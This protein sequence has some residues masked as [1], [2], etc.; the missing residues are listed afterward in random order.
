[1]GVGLVHK[2]KIKTATQLERHIKGV[3]NHWRINILLLIA[4]QEGI[5]VDGITESLNGNFKNI[6]AHIRR[7]VIA[8]LIEKKYKGATVMHR[9]TPYGK[10]F[11]NFLKSF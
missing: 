3:A 10:I 11:V 8:G 2:K 6:S 1:M 9:V 7:L 4:K 5:D